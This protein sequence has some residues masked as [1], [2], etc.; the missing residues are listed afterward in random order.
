MII[1]VLA[2]KNKHV[3]STSLSLKFKTDLIKFNNKKSRL[4]SF[5]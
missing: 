1:Y 3:L 2:S 5:V 4:S